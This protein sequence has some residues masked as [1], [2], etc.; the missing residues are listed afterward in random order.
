MQNV[1]TELSPTAVEEIVAGLTQA[2][3]ETGV[4]TTKAQNFHWNVVGMSFGTLHELFEEIYKDHFEA[5]DDLAERIRALDAHA[6]GRYSEWLKRAAVAEKDG[7]QS[8]REMVEDLA[9]DQE[10]LSGVMHALASTAGKHGDIL[11]EDLAVERGRVHEKFAW[12][13]RAHLKG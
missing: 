7:T 10:T 12:M 5:Q 9:K 1:A 3:A 2:L 6:E 11:T 13:L 8:D 4:L